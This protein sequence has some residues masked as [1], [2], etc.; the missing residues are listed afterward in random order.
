VLAGTLAI[1][2]TTTTPTPPDSATRIQNRVSRLATLLNLTQDQQT[3]AI[4]IFT[5]AQTAAQALDASAQTARTSLHTAIKANDTAAIDQISTT[6]GTLSGQMTAIRS[7]ADA[8]FYALLS[9]DQQAKFDTLH[10]GGF[11]GTGGL[12][13][14]HGGPGGPGH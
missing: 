1:A 6:L 10:Q 11:D 2:Q 7:K 5:N 12:G 3:K 9:V 14:G 13:H 4:A 8:A